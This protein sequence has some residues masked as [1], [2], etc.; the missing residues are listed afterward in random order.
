MK[1]I[2]A[3]KVRTISK[4]RIAWFCSVALKIPV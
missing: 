3:K 4:E 2:K 1:Y